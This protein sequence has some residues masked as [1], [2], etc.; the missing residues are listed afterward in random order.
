VART[1]FDTAQSREYELGHLRGRWTMLGEGAGAATV[2]VR[3][4]E[5]PPGG[6][7][8]PV[9]DHGRAEEIFYVLAGRGLAWHAGRTAEIAAGDCAVF[10]PRRGGHS[11]CSLDGLDVLAFGPREY[12]E[13]ARF[14][15]LGRSLLGGRMA[16]TVPGVRDGV[17]LQFIEEAALGAPELAAEPG[18]RP[19]TI[20]NLAE[21]ERREV[22]RPRIAR[23]RRNLGV[24]AGSITTGLQHVD[25]VPGKLSAPLHCHSLEEELFVVLAGD[26]AL[27]LDGEES[28]VAPGDVICRPAATG[29]AHAFRGGAEGLTYL[30]YGPRE[31]GDVCYYPTSRKLNFG[32]VKVIARIERLD[33]WDGED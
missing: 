31:A 33:Y 16:D 24:A 11:L 6:W 30:A 17:P 20:V 1:S 19:P 9:H 21:V 15:R 23:T 12:D 29:V 25:V 22:R 18:P 3:R 14:P 10:H 27:L 4:I 5:V 26:G 13:S 2:G 7:S 8:T 28:P 32:G